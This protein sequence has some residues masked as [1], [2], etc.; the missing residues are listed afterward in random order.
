MTQDIA[1]LPVLDDGRFGELEADF[2]PEGAREIV[3]GFVQETDRQLGAI[4]AAVTA[5]TIDETLVREAHGVK[6]GA[7]LVGATRLQQAAYDLE[8]TARAGV[9]PAHAAAVL[10]DAWA[11]TRARLA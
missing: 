5:G 8:R 3:D 7:M 11:A 10:R 4:V 1:G 9:D 2:G 6:G